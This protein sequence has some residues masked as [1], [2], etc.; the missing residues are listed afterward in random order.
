MILSSQAASEVPAIIDRAIEQNP[1]AENLLRAFGPIILRERELAAGLA[2]PPLDV[3]QIDREKLSSGVSVIRQINLIP[4]GEDFKEVALA[5]AAAVKEGLP[6]LADDMNRLGEWIAQGKIQPA[7]VLKFSARHEEGAADAV[8]KTLPASPSNASFLMSLV[9]RVVFEARAIEVAKALG[10]YAWEKGY[11]PV[12]GT[13]PSIALIEEQ[14]GKRFLHCSACGQDWRYTRVSC[15]Y[16]E[17]EAPG[18]MEYFYV[19]N[20]TQESAFICDQ[21]KKYLVTLYRAGHVLARDMDVSAISLVHLDMIM[22]DKGYQPM[23]PCPW[24]V[25]K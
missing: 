10:A 20:K 15:P 21:C 7:D 23:T 9:A 19:E 25:L 13:F 6:S 5:M 11:C 2:L 14:G 22:Q 18:G 1:H 3:S 16:C 8:W 17:K 4:D 12:C 24:N